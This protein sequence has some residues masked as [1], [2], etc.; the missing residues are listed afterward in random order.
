MKRQQGFSLIEVSI[1][2]VAVTAAL[3]VVLAIGSQI[4]QRSK[5]DEVVK[6]VTIY[7]NLVSG[8]SRGQP[9]RTYTSIQLAALANVPQAWVDTSVTPAVAMWPWRTPVTATTTSATGLGT[10]M[11]TVQLELTG[12]D[13][14]V[15]E[16]A[17]PMVAA[18][19]T[20]LRNSAALIVKA[21]ANDP[22]T[23]AE[24]TT[25]C[26]AAGASPILVEISM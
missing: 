11:D 5:I 7:T 14:P 12:L 15:C 3:G 22:A 13:V 24:I 4:N 8:D 1:V 26:A 9:T 17:L 19:A 2:A 25:L 20:R 21:H 16:G 18:R 23:T 10:R 6:A